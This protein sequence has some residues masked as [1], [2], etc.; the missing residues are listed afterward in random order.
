MYNIRENGL[1]LSRKR[2]FNK[3][4]EAIEIMSMFLIHTADMKAKCLKFTIFNYATKQFSYM[5]VYDKLTGLS[6]FT[7]DDLAELSFPS[8]ELLHFEKSPF[9][10][11]IL[12]MQS[13]INTHRMLAR[14]PKA[15]PEQ[16]VRVIERSPKEKAEAQ[17]QVDD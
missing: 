3:K 4:L 6:D 1:L 12:C 10:Q 9:T 14:K 16:E 11:H 7:V 13:V 15:L 5:G 2:K 17:L 8:L